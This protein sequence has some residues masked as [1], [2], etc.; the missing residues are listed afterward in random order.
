MVG[1]KLQQCT[2]KGVQ[3][4]HQFLHHITL[5]QAHD[6]VLGRTEFLLGFD[7]HRHRFGHKLQQAL[8]QIARHPRALCGGMAVN[9]QAQRVLLPLPCSNPG[10]WP[11]LA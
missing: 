8:A 4:Q 1:Q 3:H 2:D 6:L 10:A 7:L 9:E 11:Y 5:G